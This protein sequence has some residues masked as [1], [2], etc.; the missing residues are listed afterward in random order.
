MALLTPALALTLFEDAA[1]LSPL[2]RAV[3]I[4]AAS[5]GTS[6]DTVADWPVDARD[7]TLIAARA[8]AFGRHADLVADCP[9]CGTRTE[10][11]V[12]LA[13]LLATTETD[14]WL[15]WNG[16]RLALRTPTSRSI[17]A[18]AATGADL[19]ATCVDL[20]DLSLPST[21]PHRSSRAKSR[22]LKVE[23]KVAWPDPTTIA[24]RLL[25]ARPLLDIRLALTCP[26]C[27]A[28][29]AP[30]FDIT[31]CLWA[32]ITVSAGRLLNEVDTL[33]RAYHW[34]EAEILALSPWRRAAYLD[35]LAA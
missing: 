34:S 16:K 27:S 33:A 35:R 30:R 32:D 29:F 1:Q 3:R 12:D 14:P 4:A 2:D 10:T 18:A 26:D 19:V 8:A 13:D 17:A 28:A 31:A 15:D 7:R 11:C 21:P 5:T 6:A 9:A 20:A 22:D 23:N 25:A 24:D